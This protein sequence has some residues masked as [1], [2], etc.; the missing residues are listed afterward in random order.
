MTNISYENIFE[1]AI[2]A[3]QAEE[4]QDFIKVIYSSDPLSSIILILPSRKARASIK[5]CN[6]IKNPFILK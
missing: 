2:P 1:K 5:S 3:G 6:Y 4:M